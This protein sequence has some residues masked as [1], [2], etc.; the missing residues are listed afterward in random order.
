MTFSQRGRGAP[1]LTN[2]YHG[3]PEVP[4]EGIVRGEFRVVVLVVR[5][6]VVVLLLHLCLLLLRNMRRV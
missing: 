1:T 6:V 2:Q 5:H 3:H 4:P